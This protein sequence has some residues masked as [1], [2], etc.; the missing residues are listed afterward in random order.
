MP[1]LPDYTELIT[2]YCNTVDPVDALNFLHSGDCFAE[3]AWISAVAVQI[4]RQYVVAI[5]TAYA[6]ARGDLPGF[7]LTL[8]EVQE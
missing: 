1:E 6:S 2:H 5:M 4:E 8:P 7:L 3:Q